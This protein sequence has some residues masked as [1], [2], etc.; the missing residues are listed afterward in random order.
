MYFYYLLLGLLLFLIGFFGLFYRKNLLN[1]LLSAE[2]MIIALSFLV[3]VMAQFLALES[4][5]GYVLFILTA[6]FC[7]FVCGSL[8]MVYLTR[9]GEVPDPDCYSELKW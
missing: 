5:R 2:L 8:L 6:F 3:S 1:I 4:D 7:N 9:V